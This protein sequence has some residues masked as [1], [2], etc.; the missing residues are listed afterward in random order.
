LIPTFEPL[1]C[2]AVSEDGI[3]TNDFEERLDY[4]TVL[5]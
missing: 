5:D 2:A 3:L 4:R 1:G